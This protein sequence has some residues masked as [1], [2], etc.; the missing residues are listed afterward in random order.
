MTKQSLRRPPYPAKGAQPERPGGT[1]ASGKRKPVTLAWLC[2]SAGVLVMALAFAVAPRLRRD[3]SSSELTTGNIDPHRL[4]TIVTDDGRMKCMHGTFDNR[5]GQI[6]QGP[7]FCQPV[8][9]DDPLG[10]ARR[11]SAISNSFK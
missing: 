11:L 8:A 9:D 6:A 10:R 5:T 1:P 2:L 7:T 4:A 3:V